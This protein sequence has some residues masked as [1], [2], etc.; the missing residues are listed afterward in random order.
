MM[1]RLMAAGALTLTLFGAGC[2][3][4]PQPVETAEEAIAIAGPLLG[5]PKDSPLK[6]TRDGDL[7]R[8]EAAVPTPAIIAYAEVDVRTGKARTYSDEVTEVSIIIPP[9]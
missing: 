6:A 1:A 3:P 9:K 8:V 5:G 2:G 7:W 4:P